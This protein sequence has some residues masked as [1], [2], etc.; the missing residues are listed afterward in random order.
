[1]CLMLQYNVSCHMYCSCGAWAVLMERLQ[2]ISLH[3]CIP[4]MISFFG[5]RDNIALNPVISLT[6]DVAWNHLNIVTFMVTPWNFNDNLLG[7]R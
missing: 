6:S 2:S 7:I 4:L 3:S 1:M 5:K